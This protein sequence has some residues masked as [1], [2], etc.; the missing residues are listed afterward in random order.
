MLS[1]CHNAVTMSQCSHHVGQNCEMKPGVQRGEFVFLVR[2]W[3]GGGGGGG[4]ELGLAIIPF[5]LDEFY[6]H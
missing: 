5:G 6:V 1:P 3:G 4:G 2:L